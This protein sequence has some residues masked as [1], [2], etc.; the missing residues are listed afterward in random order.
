VEEEEK[1]ADKEKPPLTM[2]QYS[3]INQNKVAKAELTKAM[4]WHDRAKKKLKILHFK[5]E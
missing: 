5:H 4:F 1:K 2:S 3:V